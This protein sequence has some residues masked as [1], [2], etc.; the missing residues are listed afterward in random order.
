MEEVTCQKFPSSDIYLYSKNVLSMGSVKYASVQFAWSKNVF[1][2]TMTCI[3]VLTYL[4][5]L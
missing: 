1:F 5:S 2:S 4:N 3:G